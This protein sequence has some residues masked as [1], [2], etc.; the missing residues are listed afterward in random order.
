MQ[1]FFESVNKTIIVTGNFISYHTLWGS[2][3]ADA[4]GITLNDFIKQTNLILLN[5]DSGTHLCQGGILSPQDITLVY[6]TLALHI[7]WSVINDEWGS[8]HLPILISLFSLIYHPNPTL[9]PRWNLDKADWNIF[10]TV[11]NTTLKYDMCSSDVDKFYSIL[12]NSTLYIA[13]HCIPKSTPCATKTRKP[14]WEDDFTLAIR[15][16][17]RAFKRARM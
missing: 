17:H 4:K 5:D 7:E 10:E 13:E 2:G 16:K 9:S 12:Q 6:T 15:V 11:F 14:W 1:L 3:Q 8:D